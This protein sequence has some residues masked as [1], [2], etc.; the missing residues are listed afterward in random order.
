[1]KA[2][3]LL[4]EILVVGSTVNTGDIVGAGGVLSDIETPVISLKPKAD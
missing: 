1:V 3:E 4:S 2:G